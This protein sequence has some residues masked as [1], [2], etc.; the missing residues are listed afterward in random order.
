MKK[1]S[2]VLILNSDYSPLEITDWKKAFTLIYAKNS[3]AYVVSTYNEVI[4]DSAD[5]AY[6]V[7]A[8]IVLKNYVKAGNKRCSY[9]K[10][11]IKLRDKNTCQYCG[12]VFHPDKLNVD[13]IIPRS[14]QDLLP[15]GIR[16][17]SF[18]NIVCSCFQC[19]TK[20]SDKTLKESKMSLIKVPKSITKSEKITLEILSRNQMPDEWKPYII[21]VQK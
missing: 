18:E 20:K 21:K 17:S 7:P 11:N 6:N 13:H 5:R 1:H 19:N 8:V 10:H 14:R 3:E 16:A 2:P 15:K 9:S 12:G 4:Y